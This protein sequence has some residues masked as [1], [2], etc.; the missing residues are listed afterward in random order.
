MMKKAIKRFINIFGFDI[1]RLKP[2]TDNKGTIYSKKLT[3]HETATGKYYLPTDARKDAIVNHIVNDRIFEKEVVDVAAN[4]VKEGTSVLDIGSN[5]GQMSVLFAGMVGNKGKVYSFDADDFVY[6]ILCKN[7]H[8]NNL[9][10]VIY[11]NFGAVYNESGKTMYF[12][13]QDFE[14]FETYGSYGVDYK[15]SKGRPVKSITVDSMDIAEPI[16]FMKVDIQGGDL[17]AMKGAVNTIQKNRMPILFEYE[18]IFEDEL[19]LSFQQ[20]IDFVSEIGYKFKKVINGHNYLIL[21][22]DHWN[23]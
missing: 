21:P 20:Y 9:Q 17:E 8:A 22:Q 11:P 18:Y 14:R 15:G 19:N 12:P 23:V 4:Y 13:V 7:I 10:N 1:V 3:L 5:F 2:R 16:S 6:E